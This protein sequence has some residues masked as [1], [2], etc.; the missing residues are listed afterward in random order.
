V[1]RIAVAVPTFAPDGRLAACVESVLGQH[2]VD[3]DLLLIQN[4]DKAAGECARWEE[5]GTVDRPGCNLGVA[6][7]W[8]RAAAWA[9]GRGHDAVVLLNDDVQLT[10][11]RTLAAMAEAVSTQPRRLVFLAGR[12]FSAACVTRVVL[13]EVGGFDA[14]FWPAY[15]EDIDLHRRTGLAGIPWIDLDLPSEHAGSATIGHDPDAAAL[16]AATYPTNERRYRAK[17]GGGPAGER[18]PTPWNGGPRGGL[19]IVVAMPTVPER[20]EVCAE[21]VAAWHERTPQPVEVVVS[22]VTGGW[23]A[24]LNDVWRR[25]RGADVFVCASDDMVPEDDEWL[26]PLLDA[27]ADGALPAPCVIDPRWTNYGGFD[28][29]VPDGTPSP[30]CTF[31]VLS[32]AWLDRVFPL[33][34]DLHYFGDDLIRERLVGSGVPSVAVPSSRIRHLWVEAARGAGAGSESARMQLDEPRFRAALASTNADAQREPTFTVVIPTRGRPTLRQTLESLVL[35]LRG[36]D[37]VIVVADGEQPVAREICADF[38]RP[39]WQYLEHSHTADSGNSQ[40]EVGKARGTCDYLCFM[41]DDDA[42]VEGAFAAM[43]AAATQSP[44]RPLLFRM[45]HYGTVLWHAAE[46]AYGNVGTP[47][48]V[49]PYDRERLGRWDVDDFHFIQQT[50]QLQGEPVWRE[51]IVA[52]VRPSCHASLYA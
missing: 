38:S 37:E 20:A 15:F 47:M 19:R 9:W 5:R 17:W 28:E 41:D 33:P 6:A 24:G 18:Y 23:C 27:L 44:G 4:G 43:R 22:T 25:R 35:Q 40:R 32:R 51:E 29:P 12:G 36:E 26:F 34:D 8:N 21:T 42:Y 52:T 16:V 31:P 46:L 10:E 39:C 1:S 2:D 49:V 7:S 3:V 14:G 48:L 45:N 50:L 11:P 13:E 30:R